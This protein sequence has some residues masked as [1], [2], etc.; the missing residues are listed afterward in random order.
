M[1][2][3]GGV[4]EG[5]WQVVG[6]ISASGGLQPWRRRGDVGGGRMQTGQ[7]RAG[8]RGRRGGEGRAGV[9]CASCTTHQY[10]LSL[11]RLRLDASRL[12]GCEPGSQVRLRFGSGPSIASIS[13]A[14]SACVSD[15]STCA[16]TER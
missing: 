9:A 2:G 11:S 10:C 13:S 16:R 1:S 3:G 6:G 5:Q 4:Q 8:R 15:M 12:T 7:G 14:C